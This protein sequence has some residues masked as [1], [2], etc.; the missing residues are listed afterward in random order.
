MRQII[1]I[2][3]DLFQIR[4]ILRDRR[5]GFFRRSGCLRVLRIQSIVEFV[6]YIAEAARR[7]A[8][9]GGGRVA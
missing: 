4:Q 7:L 6:E 2:E 9:R 1:A 5:N 3:T 8:H